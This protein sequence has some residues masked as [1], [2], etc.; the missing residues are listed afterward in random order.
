MI[1]SLSYDPNIIERWLY[2][3]HK[4]ILCCLKNDWEKINDHDMFL[5][6]L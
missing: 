4:M 5:R 3:D 2:D 6:W 1:L